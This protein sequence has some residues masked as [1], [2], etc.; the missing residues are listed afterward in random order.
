[1][2]LGALLLRPEQQEVENDEHQ[3]NGD[4]LQHE[5]A[6]PTRGALRVGRCNEHVF[7][8][9]AGTGRDEEPRS[10]DLPR[11]CPFGCG[12]TIVAHLSLA[13]YLV[14]AEP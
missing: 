5:V 11:A 13:R 4:E 9:W 2:L 8:P 1:M 6:A 14:A 3:Q 10:Q 7:R 12:A